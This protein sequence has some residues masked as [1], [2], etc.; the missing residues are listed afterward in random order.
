MRFAH[1]NTH[2]PRSS[3]SACS[4]MCPCADPRSDREN[5]L[6][7]ERRI[8]APVGSLDSLVKV[9][10]FAP[11]PPRPRFQH[12]QRA[13]RPSLR[14]GLRNPGTPTFQGR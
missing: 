12:A 1:L 8:G 2:A 10:Y 11:S 13:E 6:R 14:L 9:G 3:R 4:V 5:D 7:R